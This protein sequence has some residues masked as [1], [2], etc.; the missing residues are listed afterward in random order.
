MV[1]SFAI[2]FGQG[3][4]MDGSEFAAILRRA[5]AP[6]SRRTGLGFVAALGLLG[7][8]SPTAARRRKK[9]KKHKPRTCAERCE[10]GCTWCFHRPDSATLCGDTYATTGCNPCTS[11]NDCLGTGTPYCTTH[12]TERATGERF[13]WDGL[14][15]DC[16]AYSVGYCTAVGGCSV[17]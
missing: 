3:N 10:S 8:A 14:A 7:A 15:G 2:H 9:R 5:V 17:G 13:R 1:A 6:V 4:I 11:D 12:R 16:P